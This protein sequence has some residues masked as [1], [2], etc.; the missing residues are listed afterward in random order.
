MRAIWASRASLLTSAGHGLDGLAGGVRGGVRRPGRPAPA[1]GAAPPAG[2]PAPPATLGGRGGGL[3]GGAGRPGRPGSDRP[4]ERDRHRPLGRLS[5]C[6]RRR[7][8]LRRFSIERRRSTRVTAATFCAACRASSRMRSRRARRRAWR[9][10]S[11]RT[12]GSTVWGRRTADAPAP[13]LLLDLLH[14]VVPEEGVEDGAAAGGAARRR[15]PRRWASRAS[16]PRLAGRPRGPR[17]PRWRACASVLAGTPRSPARCP[18]RRGGLEP[19][20]TASPRALLAL[21][22]GVGVLPEP[23]PVPGL[24]G[25]C[26]GGQLS[27][28]PR[29]PRLC[30]SGHGSSHR[31]STRHASIEQGEPLPGRPWIHRLCS[32]GRRFSRHRASQ[33][34]CQS[35]EAMQ[36]IVEEEGRRHGGACDREARSPRLTTRS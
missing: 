4:F 22:D 30:D 23:L 8:W 16:L 34:Y 33:T 11:L 28:A 3:G 9:R 2:W 19:I 6:P 25:G 10:S 27:T 20:P 7:L 36:R 24:R 31:R 12:G 32:G 14:V 29:L 1:A 26:Q 35:D 5:S 18:R 15:G 17:G 13:A 21:P